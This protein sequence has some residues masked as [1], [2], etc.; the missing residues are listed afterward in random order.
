MSDEEVRQ[1]F[2]WSPDQRRQFDQRLRQTLRDAEQGADESAA[3]RG[4][5]FLKSLG[6]RPRT[7]QIERGG[8]STAA[9]PGVRDSSQS[10]PPPQYRELFDAFKR[11]VSRTGS[12]RGDD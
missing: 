3:R 4:E 8:A 12:A 11:G 7:D 2:G 9:Q 1:E 6:L 5:K 10:S